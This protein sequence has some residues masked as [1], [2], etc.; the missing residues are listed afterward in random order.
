MNTYS[1]GFRVLTMIAGMFR[2]YKPM[3]YFSMIAFVL[4][5]ISAGFFLPVLF[6]YFKTGLVERFPT[7]IVCVMVAL[8]SLLSFY[9]GIVLQT[10]RHKDRSDFEE[11]MQTIQ[12]RKNMMEREEKKQ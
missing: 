5:V 11:L 10:L 4:M 8:A 9:A 6:E 3:V 12:F 2:V 7:L 1:D